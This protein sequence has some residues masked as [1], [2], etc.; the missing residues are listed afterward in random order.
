[1]A[2]NRETA[3]FFR[4]SK[5][6]RMNQGNLANFKAVPCL[7]GA[8]QKRG[9]RGGL[10]GRTYPIPGSSS[11][12]GKQ[13]IEEKQFRLGFAETNHERRTNVLQWG[14]VRFGN[15]ELLPLF[16]FGLQKE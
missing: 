6:F 4:Q 10:D 5:R 11:P 1:M 9:R 7:R 16:L 2:S 8:A 3:V 13:P 12:P 15:E 14:T